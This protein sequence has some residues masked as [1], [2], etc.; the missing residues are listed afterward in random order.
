MTMTARFRTAWALAAALAVPVAP[1]VAAGDET[2]QGSYRLIKRVLPSGKEVK[3]PNIV[4]FMTYT[5]TERNFN[6]MW[7][8]PKGAPASLSLIATYT[9]SGGKYCEKPVYWMQNNMGVPG[10][11]YEWPKEKK[12]CAEVATDDASTSFDVPGEPERM[13]FTREGFVATAKD[14]WTDTWKRVE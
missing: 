14:M 9:L 1:R 2:I 12:A 10:I 13:R 6:I 5:A 3:Y 8:D 7:K 4:G 11:F